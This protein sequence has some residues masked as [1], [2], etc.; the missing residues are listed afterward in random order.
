MAPI[1]PSRKLDIERSPAPHIA[2]M[3]LP[4][5]EPII[6]PIHTNVLE[7]IIKIF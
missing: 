6:I 4:M 2:G 7:F 3:K 1:A 5:V